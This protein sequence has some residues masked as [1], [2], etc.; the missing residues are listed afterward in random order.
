MAV[1]LLLHLAA[2]RP[3]SAIPPEAA[4]LLADAQ[5]TVKPSHRE[6]PDVFVA[7]VPDATPLEP[8][9]EALSRCDGV[10]HVELDQFRG[11]L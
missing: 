6:L 2:G 5:A 10:R 8:L 7:T 3:S 1:R 4:R 11:T 9:V